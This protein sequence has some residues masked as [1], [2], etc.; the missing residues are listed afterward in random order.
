MSEQWAEIA[1]FDGRYLVSNLG[2]VRS[3]VTNKLLKP[4]LRDGRYLSVALYRG[5]GEPM[6][7][8][9]VHTLV[10]EAFIGPREDGLFVNHIDG[11]RTNNAVSNLEYVTRSENMKHAHA[12][13]LQCNKGERHSQHKL[14]D[15]DIMKIRELLGR[16]HS[17]GAIANI[18]GVAQSV[19][20]RIKSGI[21]WSHVPA[22]GVL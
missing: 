18:F 1:G 4:G 15:A 6:T 7:W 12:T 21:A 5:G 19:I 9:I 8:R 10:A 11:V 20:S 2:A 3:N 16:G 22:G 13:G 14:K 17:Q